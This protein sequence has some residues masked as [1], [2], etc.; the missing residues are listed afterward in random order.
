MLMKKNNIFRKSHICLLAFF[1]VFCIFKSM[2]VWFLFLF[3]N[4]AALVQGKSWCKYIH[5][6]QEPPL[7]IYNRIP[8]S[9]GTFVSTM[10]DKNAVNH[11]ERLGTWH[12]NETYWFKDYDKDEQSRNDLYGS[13]KAQLT[14]HSMLVVDGHWY[15]HQFHPEDFDISSVEY[16]QIARNCVDQTKSVINAALK[17]K[18]LVEHCDS[19]VEC[20]R[21]SLKDELTYGM[22][23]NYY[24]G[25]HCQQKAAGSLWDGAFTNVYNYQDGYTMIGVVEHLEETLEML[26]CVYPTIFHQEKQRS[27]KQEI[28]R[29]LTANNENESPNAVEKL[30]KDLCQDIDEPF[31]NVVKE[32]FLQRY[33]MMKENKE[34]CCRKP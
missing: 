34:A 31:Y 4:L 12:A 15:W 11:Q 29:H 17:K 24:C 32:L 5:D 20:L 23:T 14:N 27:H 25:H 9:A 16:L 8:R 1:G 7:I 26:E 19:S 18:D 3:I 30:A 2:M 6:S 21:H 10:M 33:A 28:R 22:I 13:I